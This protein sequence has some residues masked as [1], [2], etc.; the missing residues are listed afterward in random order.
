MN[1]Y[2][3][4]DF[5]P[6]KAWAKAQYEAALP[7]TAFFSGLRAG[8]KRLVLRGLWTVVAATAAVFLLLY[9]NGGHEA[10]YIS[11]FLEIAS[12]C[13]FFACAPL[14]IRAG[15]RWARLTPAVGLAVCAAML[16]V[17]YRATD[18]LQSALIEFGVATLALVALELVLV[19]ILKTVEKDYRAAKE[20]H[21]RHR[22]D[23]AGASQ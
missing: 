1:G 21:E 16:L 10:Y 11:V 8:A 7:L 6:M 9:W 19:P 5:D 13:F 12:A 14:A 23:L 15:R 20:E 3:P 22:S 18:P 17:A 4:E 2:D